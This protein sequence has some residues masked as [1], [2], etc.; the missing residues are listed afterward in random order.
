MGGALKYT[1]HITSDV[2]LH[3]ELKKSRF[4]GKTNLF[5]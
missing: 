5:I 3:E 2:L 4:S 1:S